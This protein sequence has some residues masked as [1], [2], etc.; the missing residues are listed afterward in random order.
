M[1]NMRSSL[2]TASRCYMPYTQSLACSK[3]TLST[4]ARK[5]GTELTRATHS[6]SA[7]DRASRPSVSKTWGRS[8]DLTKFNQF[9]TLSQPKALLYYQ[10]FSNCKRLLYFFV[11]NVLFDTRFRLPY[12]LRRFRLSRRIIAIISP[13]V[14][15]N[16]F[17]FFKCNLNAFLTHSL[18]I[19]FYAFLFWILEAFLFS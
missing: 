8:K 15:T 5:D 17:S 12:E 9:T 3:E 2:A 18:R 7:P 4:G 13:S 11:E 6:F 10:C 1:Q 19:L 16:T 14:H